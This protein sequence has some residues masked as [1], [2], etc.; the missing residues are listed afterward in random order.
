[1]QQRQRRTNKTQAN[2]PSV[3]ASVKLK[4]WLK[5]GG[6]CSFRGCARKLS[7][8]GLTFEET[9]FSNIAHIIGYEKEGPRGDHPLAQEFRNNYENLMLVCTECHKLIDSSEISGNYSIELLQSYKKE[10][11]DQLEFI[12]EIYLKG[13]KTHL[14]RCRANIGDEVVQIT[15]EQMVKAISPRYPISRDFIDVDMTK[16]P[17]V[18]NHVYW[19]SKKQDI[20]NLI[21]RSLSPGGAGSEI[22]HLSVFALGPMPLLMHLG[23]CLSNKIPTDFFQR[24]RD[25]ENWSWKSDGTPFS[26][27]INKIFEGGSSEIRL[28]LSLSGKVLLTSLPSEQSTNT[29]VYEITL[30]GCDSTPTFLTSKRTLENFRIFYRDIVSKLTADHEGLIKIHIFPAIPAP[31]AVLCGRELLRKVDPILAVYDFNKINGSFEFAM[32]VN[33]ERK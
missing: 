17:G 30:D 21:S 15:P 12:Q 16:A 31:I 7:E 10:H 11:E 32:E 9:N 5:S 26:F 3:K 33:D 8:H 29:T 28:I 18:D 6:L 24:H 20:T 1:M 27:K 14:L 19:E 2:R 25:V 22:N 13:E 4:L 23:N